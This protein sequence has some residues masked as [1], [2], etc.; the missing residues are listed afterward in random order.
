M[1]KETK[2]IYEEIEEHRIKVTSRWQSEKCQAMLANVITALQSRQPWAHFLS[3]LPY[4][5]EAD[6][7]LRG[8]PLAGINFAGAD[9]KEVRLYFADLRGANLELCDFRGA[10]LSDTNLSDA[11]LA[12]ADFEGC[13]MMSINL[14]KANLSNAQLMRVVLTGS[15]LVEANFS[16]ADLTGAL[17]LGAKLE[18]KVFDGAILQDVRWGEFAKEES[19][20]EEE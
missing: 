20:G 14:T 18:G 3:E 1:S 15:N 2:D 10:D 4:I 7:D 12:G 17:L 13:F 8:A 6:W 19:T 11:N 16:G 5:E 9:F